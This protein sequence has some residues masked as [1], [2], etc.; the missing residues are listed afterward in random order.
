MKTIEDLKEIGFIKAGEWFLLENGRIDFNVENQHEI[1]EDILY[2]FESENLVKYIG[3]TEQNLKGRLINYKS[4][5]E[6]NKSSGFTNKFVNACIKKL[7]LEKKNVN[8]Y[9]LKGESECKFHGLRISLSTGLEKSLIKLFDINS[10]LWNSRGV[11]NKKE[12][13]TIKKMNNDSRINLQENQT[14]IKLGKESFNRGF[15]LF[16]NEV[17]NLL[18]NDCQGMDIIYKEKIISGWFTRSFKNKKVN[19]Y[20]ELK[21]IFN[22]DFRFG[23][24]IL[25]TILNPNEIKI[26]KII[27][28]S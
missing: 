10:N 17:D 27:K 1:L 26:E 14:I 24:D 6:E 9:F 25:V 11:K 4:G 20:L 2:A 13:K 23:E 28:Y 3:I 18:P 8:I 12:N 22:N 15:I 21:L 7:L 5:H 16:K 19:G